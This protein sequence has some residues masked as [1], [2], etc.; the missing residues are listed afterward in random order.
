MIPVLEPHTPY[1]YLFN[2]SQLISYNIY[3]FFSHACV[4]HHILCTYNLR[5]SLYN[6]DELQMNE[7]KI[8]VLFVIFYPYA[9][10]TVM[11]LLI[12]ENT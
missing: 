2:E 8:N 4:N 6:G 3:V 10:H 12:V 5:V 7:L 11:K 1:L 9:A